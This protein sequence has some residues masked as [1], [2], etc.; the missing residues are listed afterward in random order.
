MV[1]PSLHVQ[2]VRVNVSQGKFAVPEHTGHMHIETPLDHFLT[3]IDH[4]GN[5]VANRLKRPKNKRATGEEEKI[6]A[7]GITCTRIHLPSGM[8]ALLY[9]PFAVSAIN[10]PHTP[11]THL[12]KKP[13][14]T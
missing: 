3:S 6:S 7:D 2:P 1:D 13:V 11:S 10:E 9:T 14:S 12:H 5:S 8:S 4:L